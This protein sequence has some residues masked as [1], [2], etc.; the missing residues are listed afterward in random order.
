ME[1][2]Y[3]KFIENTEK[4][5]KIDARYFLSGGF[6]LTL[7][8]GATVATSLVTAVV[9]ANFLSE[10]DYGFYKYVL[11]LAVLFTTFSLTGLPQAIQQ[12]AAKGHEAFF[13]KSLKINIFYS[14]GITV[15]AG[16]TGI[17]YFLNDNLSLAAGCA[18]IAVLQPVVNFYSSSL[19]FSYGTSNY[20]VGAWMQS[21]KS[22]IVALSVVST[23]LLTES[24]LLV[25]FAYFL[26]QAIIAVLF[27]I[28]Q[29]PL[30]GELSDEITGQYVAYARHSSFRNILVKIST[31]LDSI[32]VFQFL[33]ASQ[34]A[35]YSISILLV[36]QVRGTLKNLQT[37]LMPKF[38]RY[39]SNRILWKIIKS[40]T[41]VLFIAFSLIAVL[42]YLV[43]PIFHSLLFPKY[44]EA[45]VYTQILTLGIPASIFLVPLGALRS[46]RLEKALYVYETVTSI[47]QIILLLVFIYAMGVLGVVIS[48]VVTQ[49]LK[50]VIAYSLLYST[51]HD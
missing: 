25:I 20:R 30:I 10:N 2:V 4:H 1:R 45:I 48:R 17:Y 40:K 49:W 6:F 50:A 19:F 47:G 35:T 14:L 46:Q 28:I 7:G 27:A 34:L 51:K 37:L 18:M 24:V 26:S 44:E 39:E 11:G 23:A 16:L 13:L 8:Q 9:L 32:L 36:D 22:I 3:S 33:G 38:S 41:P 15:T 31:N 21:I 29:K 43:T 42:L 12:A 5:L